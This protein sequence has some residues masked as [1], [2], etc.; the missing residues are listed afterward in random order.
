MNKETAYKTLKELSIQDLILFR[1]NLHADTVPLDVWES[2]MKIVKDLSNL[3]SKIA[4]ESSFLVP[5]PKDLIK[6]QI[7][8][9]LSPDENLIKYLGVSWKELEKS[10]F[11]G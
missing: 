1:A 4:D 11:A 5:S 8:S 7:N 9:Y 6:I 2:R 10:Y 3:V